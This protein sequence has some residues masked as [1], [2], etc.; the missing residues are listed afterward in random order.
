[1]GDT[2][3]RIGELLEATKTKKLSEGAAVQVK[4]WVRTNRSSGAIGFI[5]LNDG[6]HFSNLQLVYHSENKQFGALSKIRTGSALVV[7][8]TLHLT[9]EAPQPLEIIIDK[10][11]VCGDSSEDYPLQ[12]KHH[13]FEYLREIPHLRVR[14]N[15]FVALNRVRSE[16]ANLVHEF[17]HQEGFM[18]IHTPIMTSNDGEGAGQV[19][20]VYVNGKKSENYFGGKNANLT[21][22]GQLHVEPFALTFGRVY[23]F[24]PTFRAEE[25]N[26]NRHAA[27]FWMIEPEM[28]FTDLNGD[29]EVI[30][31]CLKYCFQKIM[32]RCPEEMSF[33]DKMIQKGVIERL[34]KLIGSS[35]ER[36][37]YTKAIELLEEAVKNGVEFEVKKI[38]WG[39]DLQSEHERYLCEKIIKGPLFLTDYPR[40]IKAFYMR[41]NDDQKTVAAV[42]L[43]VPGV[44]EI[45]GGSEREDRY[46]ILKKRMEELGVL[47]ELSWYLD[48]RRYGGCRHSG[49]GIGFDR[50]LMYITGINNIRDA[51]PYPRTYRHMK[52]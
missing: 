15:T 50:L 52:L 49:F 43:L 20:D 51:Q 13:T 1:M 27:E 37:S 29:M 14:A 22:T 25:S 6:S 31:K 3:L 5:S 24:G 30:E 38:H 44:G 19:F 42:D 18:W 45:V 48:L 4:G 47:E 2:Y 16:L 9:P 10:V 35:F 39:M 23:T 46:D 11:E 34:Q 28:A 33:F 21:V 12:K 17:F 40:D 36:M 26:T 7:D 41:L 32:E 8:G